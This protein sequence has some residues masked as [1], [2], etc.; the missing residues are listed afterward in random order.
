MS[1]ITLTSKAML[2][3]GRICRNGCIARN[4]SLP[5]SKY[6]EYDIAPTAPA[7]HAAMRIIRKREL[8]T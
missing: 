6:S 8:T 2:F 4:R 5:W 1:P 3:S 7:N